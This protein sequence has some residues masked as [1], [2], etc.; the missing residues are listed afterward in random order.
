MPQFP[1]WMLAQMGAANAPLTGASANMQGM[2]N[3]YA[4]GLMANAAGV[5]GWEQGLGQQLAGAYAPLQQ[6][7]GQVMQSGM[8]PQ[9]ALYARTAQQLQEQIRAAEAARGIAMTPYG[10][11]VEGQTM[12]NFNIDWQNQQLQRQ[13][14]AL[15]GAG[16]ALGQYG[17]GVAGGAGLAQQGAGFPI[18]AMAGLFG[19]QNEALQPQIAANQAQQQMLMSLFSNQQQQQQQARQNQLSGLGGLGSLIGTGLGF[20]L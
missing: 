18:G 11:G 3:Q 13:L 1:T 10:A 16:G 7:A 2:Y 15:Q 6:G 19:A 20:F 5:G 9:N 12:A 17:A 8:D 14:A 4:P